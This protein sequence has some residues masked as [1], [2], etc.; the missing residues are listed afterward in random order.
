MVDRHLLIIT[1]ML[2]ALVFL[3]SCGKREADTLQISSSLPTGTIRTDTVIVLKFSRAV[4]KQDSVNL[5]T[6][7]PFIEFTPPIPG[8]FSWQDS[9][10]LLFSPDEGFPG[11]AKIRGKINT[12]LLQTMSGA[13]SFTGQ[14]E[15]MFSTE[16]FYMKTVEFFYDR[17][18]EKRKIGIRGNVEFT[19]AVNPTDVGKFIKVTI[20]NQ[21]QTITTVSSQAD[22]VI[23][24]EIGTVDQ[25]EKAKVI[26]V[27]FDA[28]LT[29]TQTNTRIR[30]DRPFEFKLPGIEELKIY[31]HDFGLDGANGWIT[32]KTSQEIDSASARQFIVLQPSRNYTL[33]GDRQSLTLRGKFEP[34]MS[35]HLL[36]KKGLESVLQAKTQ[37][38]YEADIIIGNIKPSFRFASSSGQYMLLAGQKKLELKSVNLNKISVRVSQ[39]F[40]NNLVFFLES[41]RHYDYSYEYNDEGGDEGEGYS[42]GYTRKFRYSVGNFGRQLSYDSIPVKNVANQEAATLLDMSTYIR[43]D[44]KGFFVV[45]IASPAEPWRSTAKLVSMSNIGLIV[46]QSSD[47]LLV[48]ATSLET[49]EP[50]SGVTI[51][52]ISTN[53]QII[54]AGKSDGDGV[55]RFSHWQEVQNDF[56]LKL[57]TAEQGNDFNFINLEDYRLETSRFDASGK[58]DSPNMYDSFLY[59]DRNIYRPGEKMY[60]SGIIR[61]LS[62][63]LPAGMPVK[64]KIMNPRGTVVNELQHTLNEQGSF[65]T[66]YQ[67]LSS[68]QTGSYQITLYTG[69]D[70][71]LT[72][73]SVSVE[74]FVPDRLKVNLKPSQATAKP[75]EKLTYHLLALNFFGPPAANRHY[76]FEGSFNIIPYVSKSFS[77]FRFSD[78]GAKNYSGTP[79]LVNGKTDAEGTATIEFPLPEDLTSS[80]LLRAR[81]RVA[82]FDESGRPV[83]QLAQTTIYPKDYFIGIKTENDYYISPNSTRKLEL[84]AVDPSDKPIIGFKAKVD[85]IRYEWHSILRRHGNDNTLRYVSERQEMTEK[86]EVVTLGAQPLAYT[87]SVPRSGEYVVRVSKVDDSG[88]NQFFFYAYSWGTSDITSFQVDPEARVQIVFDD[89]VYAPGRTA[90]ILFQTPFSGKMLVTV[91]RNQVYSYRYV[92]VVNNSASMDIPVE[93][94]FLPNVYVTAVL[95]RKINDLNIPLLAGHGIAP[96]VVEKP[97]NKIGVNISAPEKIRPKTKQVVTVN[98]GQE[99]NVFVTLAAVDEGICQ[100]K[101]FRTPDP[102]GYFYQKKALETETF[103]F[104]KHLLPEPAKSSTGGSDEAI[105]KRTNPLGVQR[106]KPLAIWSGILKSDANGNANV[107]LDVP[108]FNGEL[109]LMALAYKGDR[110]G[111]S[112]RG[113]KV[114]D[115]I[116]ITPALP[117]F[118][119]P[120][121]TITMPITAF[122]TTD[123]PTKLS[124]DIETEGGV[125][126][127]AKTASLEVGANQ[128]RYAAVSLASTNQ[129][130]KA[131]VKVKTNAF[132]ENLESITE[133][134][135]RPTSPFQ[136]EAI[137]DFIDAGNSVS[138]D[139]TNAYLNFGR[140]AYI[141]LSPYPV[142]NFAKEL[143]YLVGYP[144]GCME[145]TTSKAFPQIYLRDI[146]AILDPTILNSG[147]P[148]YFVNEAIMKV[149]SM[150][151][152]DG[153]FS[154]WPGG[155]YANGWSTV[156]ATHFLLEAKKAGYAVSEGVLKS[157]LNAITTIA[158]SKKTV[159]YYYYGP[160][161]KVTVKRIA[162]KTS[163]YALYVL[164][165]AGQ[166]EKALMNFY[167]SERGLLTTDTQ[168]L[169][170]GAFALSGDRKTSLELLPPQFVTEE[171]LRESGNTFDSP[172]RANAIILNVLLETDYDNANI[173]LYMEY[174]SKTY[175]SYRWYSTQDNAFTLLAF[176]KAARRASNAKVEGTIQ[177]GS[178]E[179]A[180]KGG[181][182]KIDIDPFGKKVTISMTGDGR[183]YYSLVTEGIRTDGKIKVEDRN[184]KI[185]REFFTRTGQPANL[186]TM[187][188]NDLIIV[189]LSLTSSVNE[190]SNVAITDLLPAGFEIE[191]PRLTEQTNYSFIKNP[192]LPMYMDIR[193]DRINLYTNFY[194]ANQIQSFYYMVRAVTAGEFNYAPVA[195]EAM[196]NADYYS[197]SGGEKV[198]VI[199]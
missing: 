93:E 25:T 16:S 122:N 163:I 187:K 177:V 174:L 190:I 128:E 183:V 32:I 49:T 142:A 88:Y 73:N 42:H 150:Q 67:T 176:G 52:L 65:E 149:T 55:V 2:A 184:L 70:L 12:T 115:P 113:M 101:N 109:R 160:G 112:Q 50:L 3:S 19:Y 114:A 77:N 54:A 9:S 130:G 120:N 141:T 5:W 178:K 136:A 124:F 66:S 76:E 175:H 182:Q 181:N 196:Y 173:P 82:V 56:D 104:F 22:R 135:I 119:S 127:L 74:D 58:H 106:F 158:R 47:E 13:K 71:Y 94:R 131:I 39:I 151:M 41:G 132:G 166:P 48:F 102:Y 139:V 15:F 20:D 91:E 192:T 37:N 90:K 68:A 17:L 161:Q 14:D 86:S 185:R 191:N 62:N 108:E 133:L 116:V 72:S 83:Y 117:R 155:D 97:S 40:Q 165:L 170:S 105:A 81:G 36:I 6:E 143:K 121:D 78:E 129:I 145:Q 44:Y 84:I 125:V 148:T 167:R 137:S 69:N 35:F 159:D 1:I 89:S 61:N 59:G 188:Q 198:T 194:S 75:G 33:E 95:F 156:Y 144:H 180:Y 197:A 171:S 29:S 92:D 118:L 146:A 110:F 57:V 38:D 100:V 153:G 31:G 46:K 30:T 24:I 168:V 169:L 107:T 189:K 85:I 80:G 147:S 7:T 63:P 123:K 87:Y 64:V 10:T 51:N 152:P 199:R 53:N 179:Y 21:L 11:D 172:I 98:V 8:K 28:Q 111:S 193:D 140:K 26:K 27:D 23:P 126:A 157:A 43:T 79:Y 18:G 4:V 154:Y 60:I 96:L 103:D 164:A 34:G 195:A 162:D 99:Q 186:S 134:P 138:H 45:E